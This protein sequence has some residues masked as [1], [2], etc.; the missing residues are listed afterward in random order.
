M[1]EARTGVRPEMY[2]LPPNDD[3]TYE[4]I[5]TG[6]TIGTFQIESRAQIASVLHTKPDRLYDI[7]VQVALIRPGPIQARFVH[8][9]TRRRRGLEPVTYAHPDLEPILKRTQGI[10]IFQ[11]QAMAIAMKL[12]GYTAAQADE[13][14]RTMGHVRKV[15]RLL[16]VLDKLR[17][18]MMDHGVDEAVATQIAEDLRSFANYGFPESH[19]WSFALIS[20]ATNYLKAHY[21]AE[22][23]AGLLNSWPMGFYP[24]STL[25]HDAR[26]HGLVVLPPCMRDGDW[27]CTIAPGEDPDRPA[28]RVGWR[29]IRGLGEKSLDAL[30]L[31]RGVEP[32]RSIED[33]VRRANLNRTDALHLSRAGAF[34]C[35]EPDRRRAGWIA[36]RY[37]GDTLPLAPARDQ[38][39]TPRPF[40]RDELI[41][42]DYF[43]TGVSVNGHPMEHLRERCRREG[44]VDS[45]DLRKLKGGESV[46]TTGLVT[47]RQ[48]PVSANGTIFL[49]M[50][51][52]HGFIN[53]VVPKWI[54][55]K[56]S[57]P[58]H[59]ATFATVHG[60]FE[61]D[62]GVMNVV[63]QRIAEM[64]VGK[65]VHAS[66]DFH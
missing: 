5:S 8:P 38:R 27:E 19:A 37:V 13:L 22:F 56:Y 35:W 11:E 9:Y 1:I 6:E 10:P 64:P 32:F 55:Q 52:E 21:P 49:L 51:D 48:R 34:G 31:A 44:M 25:I 33:V 54:A 16:A 3:K 29:H 23:Y 53:I 7:V 14:R 46:V 4:L 50:E 24:P 65:L 43:S 42:L 60:K 30:K 63:A 41:F 59:F 26:R 58:V 66:R 40:T 61:R 39:Y 36:L 17:K 18:A 2:K 28:M 57:E 12:G 15:D 20:Y 62:D 45:N 47:I